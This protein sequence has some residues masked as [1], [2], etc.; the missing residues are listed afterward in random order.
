MAKQ[1]FVDQ[2][3]ALNSFERQIDQFT[4]LVTSYDNPALTKRWLA[5]ATAWLDWMAQTRSQRLGDAS[6][7]TPEALAEA[8]AIASDP[9]TYGAAVTATMADLYEALTGDKVERR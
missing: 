7:L 6:T 1:K 2:L 8:K 4:E 3:E 9:W 5:L